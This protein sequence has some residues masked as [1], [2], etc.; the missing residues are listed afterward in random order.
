[1]AIIPFTNWVLGICTR[2]DR[3]SYVMA[4]LNFFLAPLFWVVDLVSIIV[5]KDIKWLA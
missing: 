4:V 1:L 3:E 5:N 2:V